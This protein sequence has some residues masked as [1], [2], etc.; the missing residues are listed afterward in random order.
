MWVSFN[1]GGLG[2]VAM[3]FGV[4]L[5]SE[6]CVGGIGSRVEEKD[7]DDDDAD[8][9]A[10]PPSVATAVRKSA[11]FMLRKDVFAM[12]AL[13]GMQT[14]S[15]TSAHSWSRSS[16]ITAM[17]IAS[18]GLGLGGTFA[19][20]GGGCRVTA[21]ASGANDGEVMMEYLSEWNGAKEF[22]WCRDDVDVDGKLVFRLGNTTVWSWSGLFLGCGQVEE[23]E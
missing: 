13:L 6:D 7:D 20:V 12:S 22:K 4:M 1:S 18:V 8:E 19:A 15:S 5:A 14:R 23:H 17:V 9:T 16:R 2:D 3:W 10:S 11:R 21:P